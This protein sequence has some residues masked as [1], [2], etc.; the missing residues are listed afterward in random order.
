M[1]YGVLL[2]GLL[3]AAFLALLPRRRGW[4]VALAVAPIAVAYLVSPDIRVVSIHGLIHASMAYH[5][6]GSEL[7]PDNPFF[8]GVPIHYPWAFH[9]AVALVSS[10]L[11]VTPSWVFAAGNLISA[12]L[13][14]VLVA[15]ISRRCPSTPMLQIT[16]VV[17]IWVG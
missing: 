1:L 12:G 4:A 10:V 3:A 11:Q 15:K 9:A 16:T 17:E 13:I 5:L 14:C 7:P 6:M 2:G 8:A